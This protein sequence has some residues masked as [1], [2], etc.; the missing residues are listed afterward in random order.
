MRSLFTLLFIIFALQV[1]AQ[2]LM[3]KEINLE[4]IANEKVILTIETPSGPVS[5]SHAQIEKIGLKELETTTYWPEDNG[6]Y[7][8]VLLR[9][10]LS[11]AGIENSSQIKV[12]ALDDYSALI[13]QEDWQ[14]WD[15]LIATRHER[16]AMSI[17]RKGPLRVIYPKDIGGEV[18]ASDM[19]IRWIWAIKTIEP[20][21]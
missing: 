6:V 21:L 7:D 15:V 4:P 19:R 16:K 12:T 14:K 17:R 18:A 2:E 13:P 5:Y 9:D 1:E 11:H 10:L 20:V 3:I 8:G